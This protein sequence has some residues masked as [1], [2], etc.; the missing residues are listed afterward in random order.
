MAVAAVVVVDNKVVVEAAVVVVDNKVVVEA[1]VAAAVEAV[2]VRAEPGRAL[3][4]TSTVQTSPLLRAESNNPP[5]VPTQSLYPVHTTGLR[6]AAHV[7]PPG[8]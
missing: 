2:V 5:G 7:Y 8:E 4:P 3:D 1:A 6:L